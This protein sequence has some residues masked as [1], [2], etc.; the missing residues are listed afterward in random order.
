MDYIRLKNMVFYAYHGVEESEKI[1]GA[2]FEIDLTIGCD[3]KK[4]SQ[5]DRLEDT[6]NYEAVYRDI[7]QIVTKD[8]K[9]LIESIA[10]GIAREIKKKYKGISSITVVVRK[11]SVPIRGILDT[12]EVE[13]SL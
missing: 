5:S 4:A 2:R 12:V 7:E 3:L 1:L 11:P 6:L 13:I 8:K 10:G 9:H